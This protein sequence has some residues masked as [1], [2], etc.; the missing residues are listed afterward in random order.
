[1]PTS[2]GDALRGLVEVAGQEHGRQ[3]SCF[4]SATAVALVGFTV[5]RTTS[6]ARAT[7]SQTTSIWPLRRPTSTSCPSTTLQLRPR[8]IAKASTGGQLADS[9]RAAR[10]I[11]SRDRVLARGLDAARR[12]KDLLTSRTVERRD[13]D[14]LELPLGDGAGLVEDDRRRCGASARAPRAP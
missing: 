13:V 4:S 11:A 12:R 14:E 2:R 1:M 8:A 3:P 9:A 10:T 7:P 6:V 5:S